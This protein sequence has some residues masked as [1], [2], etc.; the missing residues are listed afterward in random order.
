M[1]KHHLCGRHHAQPKSPTSP[2]WLL[3]HRSPMLVSVS[4]P[5]TP[6]ILFPSICRISRPLS[7]SWLH[8]PGSAT[9][10]HSGHIPSPPEAGGRRR[11]SYSST[12]GILEAV[13]GF[14]LRGQ[15]WAG[16]RLDVYV[17]GGDGGSASSRLPL[18]S[19]MPLGLREFSSPD[20]LR[21]Q[22]QAQKVMPPTTKSK[23]TNFD[24][25]LVISSFSSHGSFLVLRLG[26]DLEDM[27]G[28]SVV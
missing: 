4:G 25:E 7:A 13:A 23:S 5:K 3:R 10:D 22:T 17:P 24:L 27:V 2:E 20:Q 18:D 19:P 16:Q 1:S 28:L 9:R 6:R 8:R 14:W 15:P 26:L 11:A 12:V 21:Q